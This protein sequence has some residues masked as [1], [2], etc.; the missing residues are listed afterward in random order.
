MTRDLASELVIHLTEVGEDTLLGSARAIRARTSDVL[1]LLRTDKRFSGPLT[2]DDRRLYYQLAPEALRRSG[3][4]PCFSRPVSLR[5]GTDCAR[6]YDALADGEWH[7]SSELQALRMTVH[8]RISDLRLKHGCTV[9]TMHDPQQERARAYLY[10]L[11]ATQ[12]LTKEEAVVPAGSSSVS[13]SVLDGHDLI[14]G[15]SPACHA[16]AHDDGATGKGQAASIE[17]LQLTFGEAA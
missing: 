15:A 1:N 6:L 4:F 9:E 13:G 10:R 14:P 16:G 8:S 5:D 3:V 12:P 11:V 17:P 2:G 7:S